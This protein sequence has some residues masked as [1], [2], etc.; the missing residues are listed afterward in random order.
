MSFRTVYDMKGAW[1]S[2][3]DE[4]YASQRAKKTTGSMD[5]SA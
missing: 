4:F 2:V 3:I 5:T 1:P